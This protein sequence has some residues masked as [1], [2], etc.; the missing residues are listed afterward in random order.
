[1]VVAAVHKAPTAAEITH[2]CSDWAQEYILWAQAN[3]I[4]DGIGTDISDMTATASRAE[5][6]AFLS[7]FMKNVMSK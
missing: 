7:R 5:I 6:A 2:D 4:L 1:M 3:G